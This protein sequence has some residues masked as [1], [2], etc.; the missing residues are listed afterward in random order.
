MTW[1]ISRALVGI[2][3]IRGAAVYVAI[4]E[5]RAVPSAQHNYYK[6]G[7]RYYLDFCA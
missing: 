7:L 1:V 5:K 6:K 2:R 4:L 3:K